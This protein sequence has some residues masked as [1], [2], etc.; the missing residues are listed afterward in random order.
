MEKQI[1][2]KEKLNI[3]SNEYMPFVMPM[4]LLWKHKK[5]LNLSPT[6]NPLLAYTL[7]E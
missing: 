3:T 7:T 6:P 2:P 4:F 5:R 1:F